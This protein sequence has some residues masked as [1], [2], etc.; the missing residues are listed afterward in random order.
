MRIHRRGDQDVG[1]DDLARRGHDGA[2]DVGHPF[3]AHRAVDVE[4]DAVQRPRVAETFQQLRRDRVV[5]RAFDDTARQRARVNERD[6][7]DARGQVLV[8]GQQ[9]RA[10][11]DVEVNGGAA[12]R[13][14]RTRLDVD[15][16]DG[17]A[18]PLHP[19]HSQ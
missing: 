2:L 3:D 5:K 4:E 12:V 17:D 18:Q 15:A 14:E 16:A 19:S 6:P 8:L 13:R 10:A 11:A 1:T 9:L 7:N